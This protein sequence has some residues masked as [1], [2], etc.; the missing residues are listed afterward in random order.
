MINSVSCNRNAFLIHKGGS[1]AK[2]DN[3]Q[4]SKN[5]NYDSEIKSLQSQKQELE[6][7]IKQLHSSSSNPTNISQSVKELQNQIDKIQSQ[8][9]QL[10][11]SEATDKTQQSTS[12]K[13]NSNNN[14]QNSSDNEDNSVQN[15]NELVKYSSTYKQIKVLG[16]EGSKLKGRSQE[17]K[18]DADFDE[19][20]GSEKSA[21]K[22]RIQASNLDVRAV[23]IGNK[24]GKLD[25]DVDKSETK[26]NVKNNN[27]K[28]EV[29]A[30]NKN[31]VDK[32]D[33][34]KNINDLKKSINLTA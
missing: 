5:S 20:F 15:I 32:K 14:G 22:E 30:Y 28:N 24:I 3:S 31:K 1:T 2:I 12:S 13:S 21:Q 29:E 23:Y 26:S 11:I 4:S 27:K 34:D 10:Q 18:S 9:Q 33:H 19:K 6:K 8:I 7:Q 25:A 16:S 17:L